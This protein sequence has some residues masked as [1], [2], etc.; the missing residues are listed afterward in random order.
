[1]MDA[2]TD[3]KSP[4]FFPFSHHLAGYTIKQLIKWGEEEKQ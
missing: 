3:S 2:A 4:Y 1:M